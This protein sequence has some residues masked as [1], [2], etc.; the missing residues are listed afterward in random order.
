MLNLTEKRIDGSFVGEN[1]RRMR[2]RESLDLLE[3]LL[4]MAGH[5]DG[6]HLGPHDCNDAIPPAITVMYD[7]RKMVFHS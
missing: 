5:C 1:D 3:H 4:V 6:D 7:I 2:L